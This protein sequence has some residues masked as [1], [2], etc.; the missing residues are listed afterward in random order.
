MF[1]RSL[2]TTKQE[3]LL[4][5]TLRLMSQRDNSSLLDQLS[6]DQENGFLTGLEITTLTTAQWELPLLEL[7]SSIPLD[8]HLSEVT[9]VDSWRAPLLNSVPDGLTLEPSIRSLETTTDSE[10]LTKNHTCGKK[11][12]NSNKRLPLPWDIKPLDIFTNISG[13]PT[14]SEELSGD[15]NPLSSQG[16]RTLMPTQRRTS[17]SEMDLSSLLSTQNKPLTL[18]ISQETG[19]TFRSQINKSQE[20]LRFPLPSLTSISSLESKELSNGH[21]LLL[22]KKETQ[23]P[24][25]T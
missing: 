8:T 11:S 23:W 12:I 13:R 7:C 14:N 20:T 19:E 24:L 17:W 18:S 1:T 2:D 16:T 10:R 6:L 21:T 4:D 25:L 22:L 9:F 5:Y 15:L 3:R